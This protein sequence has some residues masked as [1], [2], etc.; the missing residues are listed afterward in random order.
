MGASS[1]KAM[2]ATPGESPA[3]LGGLLKW[4]YKG[5]RHGRKSKNLMKG[6]GKTVDDVYTKTTGKVKAQY[7]KTDVQNVVDDAVVKSRSGY[8]AGSPKTQL[9]KDVVTALVVD[10]VTGRHGAKAIKN[11]FLPQVEVKD[12][13]TGDDPELIQ[14]FKD[15]KTKTDTLDL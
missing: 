15:R 14:K 11:I 1:F 8:G 6:G 10:Q 12:K 2:G 3:Q 5:I 13:Y 7:G 4:A 9:T